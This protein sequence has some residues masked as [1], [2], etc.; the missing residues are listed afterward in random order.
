MLYTI[1]NEMDLQHE[2]HSK[3]EAEEFATKSLWNEPSVS[4]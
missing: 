3:Y 1:I 4:N 2:K